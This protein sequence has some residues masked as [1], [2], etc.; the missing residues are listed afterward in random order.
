MGTATI[1]SI[2]SSKQASQNAIRDE[3]ALVRLASGGDRQA[4]QSIVDAHKQRMFTVARSVVV[5]AALAEDVVQEAFIKAY[6][7]LPDFRGESRLATWLFRIT[8]LAAIDMQRKQQRFLRLATDPE[9]DALVDQGRTSG[10]AET[11]LESS[12]LLSD[13]QAA[14]HKLSPFEQ[15][16]FT[17]RHMQNFKLREIA[18]VV[19]RSEGTV[20]NILFRAIR[21]MRDQLASA[22]ASLQE[23][24]SC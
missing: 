8:Y 13:I 9:T 3:K 14:I 24:E 5:D 1:H 17:L 6:R 22:H 12:E 16:V 20:K 19:D 11:A 18:E 21:K 23:I 7:A 15:T 4:F 10:S 2:D